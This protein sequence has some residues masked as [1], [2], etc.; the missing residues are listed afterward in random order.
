MQDPTPATEP[1]GNEPVLVAAL[2]RVWE[3]RPA[4]LSFR[5]GEGLRERK[6]RLLRQQI[7][8]TA[9]VMFLERGFDHVR[10]AEIAEACGVSEKTIYNYFPTKESLVFDREEDLTVEIEE[11]FSTPGER[12]LV[13]IALAMLERD[14]TAMFDA[15]EA[16]GEPASR[17]ASIREFGAMVE[18]TPAL[19]AAFQGMTER[20]TDATAA[21]LARR[22]GVDPDDPEPQMA[23]TILMGLWRT[24]FR[25]MRRYAD[26]SRSFS[27]ARTAVMADI[28]RAAKVAEVGLSSFDLVLQRSATRQQL[29]EAA[30]AANDARKQV[31]AAVKQARTAWKEL[32][33]EA[34][35]MHDESRPGARPAPRPGR[36][37][38]PVR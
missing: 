9:T 22:A 37:G 7:S 6:K 5:P 19:Q 11:A 4:E 8:D 27:Q 10:I 16:S 14:V 17:M 26:G 32:A 28:R 36:R 15:W 18:R 2:R 25:A 1:T 31:I 35:M 13:E 21:S 33:R 3:H 34:K 29:Q 20:L 12:S 38:G 30:D 24:Q 23:A